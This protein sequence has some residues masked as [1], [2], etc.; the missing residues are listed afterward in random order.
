M[1]RCSRPN[2]FDAMT[3]IWIFEFTS[4]EAVDAEKRIP[5]YTMQAIRKLL[6][7]AGQNR[8]EILENSIALPVKCDVS[9][10]A[11]MKSANEPHGPP[12]RTFSFQL[13]WFNLPGRL[14]LAFHWSCCFA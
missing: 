9:E 12:I 4:P 5:T 7:A 3:R 2:A 10:F 13:S 14:Q 8:K 11:S 6:D 1:L